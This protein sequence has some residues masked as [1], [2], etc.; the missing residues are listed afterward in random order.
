MEDLNRKD[1]Y[2]DGEKRRLRDAGHLLFP[3]PLAFRLWKADQPWQIVL[4]P[5]ESHG[6]LVAS[7][8]GL[9][10]TRPVEAREFTCCP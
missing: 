8:Y 9:D 6:T 10:P 1:E 4:T 7:V 2:N 3:R 5:N